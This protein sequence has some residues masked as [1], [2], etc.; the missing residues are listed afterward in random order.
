VDAIDI[1]H[2][3]LENAAAYLGADNADEIAFPGVDENPAARRVRLLQDN[4]NRMRS[5][6]GNDILAALCVSE[7]IYPGIQERQILDNQSRHAYIIDSLKRPEEVQFLRRVF[8][9]AFYMIGVVASDKR[10]FDRLRERKGYDEVTFKALSD[11]DASES[12]T[13]NGQKSINTV[14]AAD[15]FFSNNF[16]T[17]EHIQGEADRLL[18]LVF[19]IEVQSPRRDEV[20]MHAASKA[21]KRSACL[22]RQVGAAIFDEND[23]ILATGH[24]DVPQF[25]G[26]LY[27]PESTRDERCYA[28][29]AKCYNDE[30]KRLIVQQL[31]DVLTEGSIIEDNEEMRSRTEQVL[32]NSRIRDLIE[33]SRA[34]H[35]E[36]DAIIAVARSGK[37]GLPGGTLYCTTFPCHNCAKHIIDAGIARVV[38]LEPY[39]KSL[40]RKLHAD[41]IN[42]PTEDRRE[43]KIAFDLYGGVAPNR[44]DSFFSAR[45]PRKT[46]GRFVDQD[47]KRDRLLPI[48]AQESEVALARIRFV[49]QQIER[50]VSRDEKLDS[51]LADDSK[52]QH[53]GKEQ[54]TAKGAGEM[55]GGEASR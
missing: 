48:G 44:Y 52:L 5:E 53:V 6:H 15:Y 43:D 27:D 25:G 21:A 39:E 3:F 38:Y 1:T 30:E 28:R 13:P 51:V 12:S 31:I 24:N 8:R 37:S 19:G 50:I 41:A 16:D 55:S 42:P 14:V 32:L 33:F 26:G 22:S 35:A 9:D 29:G 36:T 2:T 40:A 34:V 18:R 45:D 10:R 11:I 54:S 20:G 17:K 23:E 49:V 4:G 46:L 47:R 7:V